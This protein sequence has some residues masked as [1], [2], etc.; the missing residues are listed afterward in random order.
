LQRQEAFNL[1]VIAGIEELAAR[2]YEAQAALG[3]R[4]LDQAEEFSVAVRARAGELAVQVEALLDSLAIDE[5]NATQMQA[6]AD[7][8][9]SLAELQRFLAN[10]PGR[11]VE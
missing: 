2:L 5:D 11:A 9:A 6:A 7:L 8:R 10:Q 1:R 3:G 4:K